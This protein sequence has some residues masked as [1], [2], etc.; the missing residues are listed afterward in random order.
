MGSAHARA[1]VDQGFRVV[2]GDLLEDEGAALA[3][4]LGDN[5]IFARL[6]V[7]SPESWA[8]I[9]D[10]AIRE[11]G[12]IDGLVNNAGVLVEER[13]ETT[14]L[15]SW[16]RTIAV[17]QT[18]PFLGMQAVLPHIR[19]VGGGSIVNV[20]SI[21]G[22]VGFPDAFS[23]VASKWALRG[24]TKAAAIELGKDGIRVNSIHPGDT[25]TPM[26]AGSIGS[27]G[28]VV[29]PTSI[30]LGRF[31]QPGDVAGLVA[32]LIGDDSSYISGAE[33]AI[34]GAT[35]AGMTVLE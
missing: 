16:Q 5:C 21:A 7:T 27:S 23:Y 24:I 17:N 30:P 25:E 10:T 6:D 1:L 18:G 28:A 34:D 20:S 13:L 9:V 15:E 8:R 26:I 11:F 19:A 35:T 4:A 22:L 12:R 2:I 3:A 29:S 32:F 31:G 14:A 33:I